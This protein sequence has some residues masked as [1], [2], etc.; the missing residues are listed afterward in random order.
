V[1][2]YHPLTAAKGQRDF[3]MQ[4]QFFNCP[5]GTF[6]CFAFAQFVLTLRWTG[7]LLVS[8]FFFRKRRPLAAIR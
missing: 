5:S 3:R 6:F 2:R 4:K 8:A 7:G 1:C